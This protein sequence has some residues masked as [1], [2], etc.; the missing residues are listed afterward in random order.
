MLRNLKVE[1]REPSAVGAAR[2]GAA[3]F[4]HAMGLSEA[5]GSDVA[6]IVTELAG[7]LVKHTPAGG[8]VLL[9]LSHQDTLEI[10]ALDKGPG[11]A[12]PGL[13]LRDGYSTAGTPGTGLGAVSRLASTFDMYSLPGKGTAV[14]ARV[15]PGAAPPPE[16]VQIDVGAVHVPHPREYLNGDGWAVQLSGTHARVLI[17][18]GL[19]HG[20][21]AHEAAQ[22]AIQS[23]RTSMHLAPSALLDSVHAALRSTR[24]AVGA[25]AELDADEQT[26]RFAGIGNIAGAVVDTQGR[27][28]LMSLNG[29]LGQEVRKI[30]EHALPWPTGSALIL[31]SDGLSSLWDLNRYPGLLHRSATLIAGVVYRDFNRG[32]D[33]ATVLVVRALP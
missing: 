3:E 20:L 23:F 17:A 8:E 30:T 7:N 10:L 1:V 13:V 18:D 22:R 19:G 21:H 9:S 32:R 24:G 12:Q 14:L 31:H 15:N 27:R 25:V 2:R 33:D 16:G 5:R 4:A 11:L 6:I 29:T 26:L 28:G